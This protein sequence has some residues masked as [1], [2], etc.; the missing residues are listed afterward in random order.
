MAQVGAK[1]HFNQHCMVK[2]RIAFD[3]TLL[4][5]VGQLR[6]ELANLTAIVDILALGA[7]LIHFCE[8]ST[9]VAFY[10][11]FILLDVFAFVVVFD[12]GVLFEDHAGAIGVEVHDDLQILNEWLLGFV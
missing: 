1:M 5:F 9:P 10:F 3:S 4:F 2:F 8:I 11:H 12:F 7:E 6:I